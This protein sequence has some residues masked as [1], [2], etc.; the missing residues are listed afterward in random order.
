MI[1]QMLVHAT[2]HLLVHRPSSRIGMIQLGTDSQIKAF[3]DAV[4]LA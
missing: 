4:E 1:H 2:S 3:S